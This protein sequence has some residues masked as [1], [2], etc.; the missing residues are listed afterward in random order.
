M[1]KL[2]TTD[3]FYKKNNKWSQLTNKHTGEFLV[4]N[5][6]KDILG[7]EKAMKNYLGIFKIYMKRSCRIKQNKS[8]LSIC[9]RYK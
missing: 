5:S 3:L 9:M 6:L 1:K 2:N 4:K 7:G 8:R